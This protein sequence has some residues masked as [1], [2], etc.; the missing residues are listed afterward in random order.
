VAGPGS[1]NS[2]SLQTGRQPKAWPMGTLTRLRSARVP[3]ASSPL[4]TSSSSSSYSNLPAT[5]M[6]AAAT[7]DHFAGSTRQACLLPS[8]LLLHPPP[9]TANREGASPFRG[10]CRRAVVV[11]LP[12]ACTS[13]CVH[14]PDAWFSTASLQR[15]PADMRPRWTWPAAASKGRWRN[16]YLAS[17]LAG[18]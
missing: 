7:A 3:T 14:Y 9:P 16:S 17:S 15:G 5:A 1:T 13:A 4:G 10:V 12:G 11:V 8:Q 18:I 6:A 2:A